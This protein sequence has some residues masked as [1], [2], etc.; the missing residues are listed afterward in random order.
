LLG[1]YSLSTNL[2]VLGA[3]GLPEP[4]PRPHGVI[5]VCTS[6]TPEQKAAAIER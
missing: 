2:A 1:A 4:G 6:H 3:S 5:G